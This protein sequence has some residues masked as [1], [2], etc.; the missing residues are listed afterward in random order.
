MTVPFPLGA[1]DHAKEVRPRRA[2][3]AFLSRDR[4]ASLGITAAFHAAILAAFLVGLKVAAPMLREVPVT[5]DVL[6]PKKVEDVVAAAPKL[7][8]PPV[9]AAIAPVI[10]IAPAPN[11]I[12]A[13]PPRAAEPPA[14]PAPL[15]AKAG[16]TRPSYFARLLA[17]LNRFKHYPPAARAAHVEGVVMVHF[18]MARS[19]KL[20]SAEIARSSGRPALDREALALMDRAQ[21]L[22]PMPDTMAGDVLDAVVP[23]EFSLHG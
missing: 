14:P 3:P 9:I 19:G 21:P 6:Q 10:D 7:A 12:A 18:V 1:F 4:L 2:P 8:A 23:V 15:P 16:E 11:A 22:P 5:V 17:Q 13:A 20:V